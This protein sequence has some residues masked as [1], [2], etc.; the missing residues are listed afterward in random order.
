MNKDMLRELF[1]IMC[2]SGEYSYNPDTDYRERSSRVFYPAPET[3]G[4]IEGTPIFQ[5]PL[6]KNRS[7]GYKCVS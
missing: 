3:S 5:S 1:A 7:K 2:L 6:T 4:K